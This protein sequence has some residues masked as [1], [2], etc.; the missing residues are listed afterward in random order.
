MMSLQAP[1]LAFFENDVDFYNQG[2]QHQQANQTDL[3][4][5]QFKKALKKNPN[6]AE[7][8]L[9]LGLIYLQRNWYDGS[10]ASTKK[11]IA[12]LEKSKKTVIDGQTYT[13]V[14]SLAYNNLGAVEL[15]KYIDATAALK[16]AAAKAHAKAAMTWF[17]KA[18]KLDPGNSQAHG[19]IQRLK[20]AL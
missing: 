8:H 6:L 9:N 5:Q 16:P 19:N 3:A 18:V 10:V 14:I 12:L 11:A 20:S 15:A 17:Q 4:E 2:V 7:A 1:A 13:Q